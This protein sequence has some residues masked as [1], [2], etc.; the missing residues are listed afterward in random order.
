MAILGRIII[1]AAA[2]A[3]V[4][5][6][7]GDALASKDKAPPKDKDALVLP[8]HVQLPLIIAPIQNR[9]PSSTPVTFY[10]KGVDTGSLGVIC[11]Y[12][13]RLNAELLQYL[14]ANPI[15]LKGRAL[16][17]DDLG[18]KV[19]APINKAIGQP[20]VSEIEVL[21]GA[22]GG[23]ANTVKTFPFGTAGNCRAIKDALNK[24]AKAQGGKK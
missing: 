14:N 16:K 8:T 13:P 6:G 3:L 19:L 20:L 4:V 24:G 1:V 17:L 5:I 2:L 18:A 23:G 10:L 7:R 11:Q 15:P 22:P 9:D 12:E 21:S